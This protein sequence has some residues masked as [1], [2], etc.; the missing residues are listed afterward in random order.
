MNIVKSKRNFG[1]QL[2]KGFVIDPAMKDLTREL[3]AM[4]I[5]YE[6]EIRIN[7]SSIKLVSYLGYCRQN[8]KTVIN[9]N[10]KSI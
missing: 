7:G 1:Q 10:M 3:N 5:N 8:Y 2:P 4:C 9:V 6:K